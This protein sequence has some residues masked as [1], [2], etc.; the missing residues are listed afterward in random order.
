MAQ[1]AWCDS[2]AGDLPAARTPYHSL[3]HRDRQHVQ[4]LGF[5]ASSWE[6]VRRQRIDALPPLWR[7][8]WQ[9]LPM[10]HKAAAAALGFDPSTWEQLRASRQD[11]WRYP[12]LLEAFAAAQLHGER[13]DAH[14]VA[15]LL[16]PTITTLG[17]KRR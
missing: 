9:D 11:L 17:I 3:R 6:A 4:R 1:R 7:Q 8:R 5:D 14:A 15:E 10:A 12:A 2:D 13:I 16:V